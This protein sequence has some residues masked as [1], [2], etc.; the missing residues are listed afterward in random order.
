MDSPFGSLDNIYGPKIARL[1]AQLSPQVIVMVSGKQW[2]GGIE[3]AFS[4]YIG[5]EYVLIKH[6][7]SPASEDLEDSILERNNKIIKTVV[8]SESDDYTSIE[9]VL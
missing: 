3:E 1:S 2:L 6:K 9:E 4:A 7:A 8:K 5:K